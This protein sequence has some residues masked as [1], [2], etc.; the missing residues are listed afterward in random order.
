VPPFLLWFGMLCIAGAFITISIAKLPFGIG[1]LVKEILTS[2]LL[3]LVFWILVSILHYLT[4]ITLRLL[5]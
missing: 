2:W 5:L 3:L 4:S 1:T